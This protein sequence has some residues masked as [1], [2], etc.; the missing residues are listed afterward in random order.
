MRCLVLIALALTSA[1]SIAQSSFV[2]D[3]DQV[4]SGT[5]PASDTRH[6]Y[7]LDLPAGV[8]V[9][10]IE[11]SG[12]GR[13]AD[14]AVFFGNDQLHYD[15]SS[16]PDPT[17]RLHD[18]RPGRYRI[19]V[20]NLLRY[21]LE[22][23]LRVWTGGGSAQGAVPHAAA[24]YFVA[25]NG[26]QVGP[27]SLDQVRERIARGVTTGADLVWRPGL[28]AWARA[29]AVDELAGLFAP[30]VIVPPP[31]PGAPPTVDVPRPAPASPQVDAPRV[32]AVAP[33]V[34]AIEVA[35]GTTARGPELREV[36]HGESV[37]ITCPAGCGSGA[38][39]WGSDVYTDDSSVCTAAGHAGVVDLARGG[40][41]TVTVLA[42]E[43]NYV[44]TTRHG[45]TTRTWGSWGR[46]FAFEAGVA[47]PVGA[48][49]VPIGCATPATDLGLDIGGVV[50][51]GCPGGCP[52]DA[53]V[54]GTEAYA[55]DSSVCRAAVHAGLVDAARGG[56]VTLTLHMGRTGYG[57]SVRN[58]VASLGRALYA[59]GATRSFTL[60]AAA[61][62]GAGSA[63]PAGATET[64]TVGSD[65]AAT[66]ATATGVVI[67]VPAGAVPRTAGGGIGTVVFSAEP[68]SVTPAPPSGFVAVGATYQLG[69]DA[70]ALE[71]SVAITFPVP[72]GIDM[73]DVVGLTTYDPA[74][75]AWVVVAGSVDP[76]ARTVTVWTDHLSPWA[77][78]IRP[79][80]R[81]QT[82]GYVRITNGMTR[83]G[84]Y[85]YPCR[86]D[87]PACRPGLPTGHGYGVCMVSWDLVHPYERFWGERDGASRMAT[88]ADG[89][90]TD[91]WLPD[92]TYVL[93]PFFHVTQIN[94]SPLYVPRH[95]MYVRPTLTVTMRGGQVVALG[96]DDPRGYVEGWPRCLGGTGAGSSRGPI[97]AVGTGDV[98]V[99]L[100][101]QAD[102]DVDLY[103]TDPTGSTVYYGNRSVASGGELDRDNMCGDFAWGRPENV[104]WP[105]GR[106]P[107]GT[108]EVKVRYY[109]SCGEGD[110]VVNW[111]VRTVVAGRA[112]SFTGTLAN[113]EEQVVTTFTLP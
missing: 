15:I 35:C 9:L 38:A 91:W 39:V 64:I 56:P 79:G 48:A 61:A 81:A 90:T 30:P 52:A 54:W 109:G 78:A 2:I 97:T 82:G 107:S 53:P 76:V 37:A 21:P 57:A 46:S 28:D 95:Q 59:V 34:A 106:A 50:T 102:V 41:A 13:D 73:A 113:R 42:G 85:V 45:V 87:D 23:T 77:V 19:E 18:P 65:Q 105:P 17:Y 92:G 8:Q 24:T 25:E 86:A 49:S 16:D 89:Q 44:G 27:L 5:I 58:G 70:L 1:W 62:T 40:T 12:G 43:S 69:P 71:Q 96:N 93:E 20:L 108:Y 6:V 80:G 31:L 88:A 67:D 60:A 98:Q 110:P 29:D 68:A 101:W 4:R 36:A 7:S 112:N 55:G 63:Q 94:H 26:V 83:G 100:T 51:V 33:P 111:T 66:L 11:V 10:D 104:F 99:T 75:G 72:D 3:P 74:E 14:L 22:Y 84:G 47:S 32:P 103:V